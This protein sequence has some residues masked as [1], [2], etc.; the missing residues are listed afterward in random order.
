MKKIFI[1]IC[2]AIMLMPC[3]ATANIN[4]GYGAYLTCIPSNYE[5]YNCNDKTDMFKRIAELE[6][7]VNQLE[8]NCPVA[9]SSGVDRIDGL[10]IRIN[11]L[12]YAISDLR[13]NIMAGLKNILAILTRK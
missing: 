7:R 9:G 5:N 2:L 8:D 1:T 6:K 13:E 10:E 3:F 11:N 4:P 12:E